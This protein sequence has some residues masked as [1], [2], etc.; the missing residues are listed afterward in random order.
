MKIGNRKIG[1]DVGGSHISAAVISGDSG[2][3]ILKTRTG[4]DSH[5]SAYSIVEALSRSIKALDT[6]ENE[7]E[8]VGIAFPGPFDYEK[9]ICAV[10]NVGGKFEQT[11]GLHMEQAIKDF[12]GLHD[13]HFKFSN[14]AH[15]FAAGAYQLHGLTS[16]RTI[17]ITLGTGFGSAFMQD[18]ILLQ[19]HP[20]IPASGAFYDQDFRD[21]KADDYF[22]TRWILNT[23]AE[24]SGVTISSVK[25][26]V[27]SGAASAYS[28]MSQYGENMGRFLLPWVLKFQCDEL[29]IGGNIGK[30]F[31]LF[32][33]SLKAAIGPLSDKINM[34]LCEDTEDCI[35]TGAAIIAGNDKHSNSNKIM[36]KTS[37]ALLP[38]T[39]SIAETG[40]YDLY[41][42]FSSGEKVYKGFDSLAGEI[43]NEKVVIIDG[44]GGVLWEKF[45]E[46]LH[47]ALV[48][49][50]KRIF[51]YDINTCLKPPAEIDAMIAA[52]MNGDDPVFGKRYTG[53]LMD[54]FDEGKLKLIHPD[55]TADISI[56]Y[57]TGAALAGFKGK[58]LY[59]DIPKNEIQYRMRAG[60]IAN[61]GA[62]DTAESTQMYKRFYFVD[63]PVLSK[64]KAALLSH[65]DYIIDEQR[66][67]QITWM[68]GEAFRST[69]NQML[70]QPFRA[71][72][73]FEAG[74]WGGNW[75]KKHIPQLNQD[76]VNY[77]W[78]FELI[79]PENGIVIAGDN[80]LL[81]VSFDYL[82][83]ADNK[84]LLG[85][86]AERFGTAF[87]IRFDFLDTFDGGNLSVQCHPRPAYTKEHFGEDFT[88]DETYYILDCDQDAAV[89]LGFQDQINPEAFKTALLDA[90]ENGV[91][92]EV[93]KYVQKFSA[94][95]HD[96]FL[97]PNGTIHAS[98]KNNLVLEISST[99]YIFTFKMYDWLRLGLNGQPRPI[100]IEHGM[101]N[102][103]FDRK[104][105]YVGNKLISHPVVEE[106]WEGGR[107][108][109]L[110]THE[111]HFYSIYRYEFTGSVSINTNNQCH[112]CMLVEGDKIAVG[113]DGHSSCFHYAETFVVPAATGNYEITNKG[114]G[115]AFVVVAHV[116]DEHC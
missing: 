112:V 33:P 109:K 56:V 50:N 24:L 65:I 92:M 60:S 110:P 13:T 72:P 108:I 64:H 42:S 27:E 10:F 71:R 107:K 34:V 76:E 51:W 116:K 12:T 89:Y 82:A 9:G 36:R 20:D 98:G 37:Q 77:A 32:G 91:E 95:K 74:V 57:G 35:I 102:L 111:E 44:Y 53:D 18:G 23:Y 7:V 87:P 49:E 113:S 48:T 80:N 4:L 46:Q 16:K 1:M 96:L 52:S 38:L 83:Y 14:D 41:P 19:I 114:G 67:E 63:W 73:W 90:Q 103:Y 105:D 88:Q 3:S 94:Q 66:I 15:C 100:N 68:K 8:S 86:A 26:L 21:A 39:A 2:N 79:T 78:S 5:D 75:M 106:E 115:K 47:A 58:L 6:G 59:A 17:F 43:C 40:T 104:G 81:E 97:I 30:A 101:N 93:E 62:N 22:S 55:P 85:K 54:F 61:L 28:V 25:E 29:V 45:R 69:L 70:Q 84:K 99:P 31:S 11:F